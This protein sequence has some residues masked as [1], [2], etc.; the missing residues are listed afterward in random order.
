MQEGPPSPYDSDVDERSRM[1][2]NLN[3]SL[4]GSVSAGSRPPAA[5]TSEEPNN[6]SFSVSAVQA[7]TGALLGS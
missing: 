3:A 6:R 5:D 4:S 2:A 1:I 7:R